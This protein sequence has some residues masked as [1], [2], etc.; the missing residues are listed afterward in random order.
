MVVRNFNFHSDW[1]PG[2]INLYFCKRQNI[3]KR[4]ELH[5]GLRLLHSPIPVSICG[6]SLSVLRDCLPCDQSTAKIKG[7]S[8]AITF[9]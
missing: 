9:M 3:R 6:K 8:G 4:T 5:L 1:I 7:K 2:A